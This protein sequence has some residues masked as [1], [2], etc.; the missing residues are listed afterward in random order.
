MSKFYLFYALKLTFT[1]IEYSELTL[2]MIRSNKQGCKYI[3]E[4]SAYSM[5]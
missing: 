4:S 5:A 1:F 3:H 2:Y